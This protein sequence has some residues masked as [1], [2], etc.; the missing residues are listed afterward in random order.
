MLI[1]LPLVSPSIDFRRDCESPHFIFV[2]PSD[3]QNAGI[4]PFDPHASLI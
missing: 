2:T 3:L 4:A 1:E